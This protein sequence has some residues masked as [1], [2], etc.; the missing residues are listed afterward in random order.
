MSMAM[1]LPLVLATMPAYMEQSH[2]LWAWDFA[3]AYA[4]HMKVL[5]LL[6][7]QQASEDKR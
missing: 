2:L 5:K 4:N 7:H 1:D 3:P 6:A